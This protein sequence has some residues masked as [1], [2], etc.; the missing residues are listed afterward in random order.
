MTK[1]TKINKPAPL[2]AIAYDAL[3]ESILSFQLKQDIVYNEMAVAQELGLSRT[4]VREALLKLASQGMVTFLPRKGFII[5][6]YTLLDVEE[7]FELRQMVETV[8]GKKIA[9]TITPESLERLKAFIAEQYKAAATNDYHRFMHSD[10]EFHNY[11]FKLADNKRL[12]AIA[13]N[14]QDLCHLMGASV[15]M[16]GNRYD[17]VIREHEAIVTAL[18]SADESQVEGAISKHLALVKKAVEVN[19]DK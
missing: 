5:S 12:L 14:F 15:I 19:L 18:E 4:P 7:I 13:N 17:C 2:S 1:L 8:V 9:T 3:R 10:R 11:F 16:A 6:S